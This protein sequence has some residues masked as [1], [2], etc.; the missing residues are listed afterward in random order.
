ME[1]RKSVKRVRAG[2]VAS[3]YPMVD[4]M[5]D[6]LR[7]VRPGKKA[8]KIEKERY[9]HALRCVK[10][11]GRIIIEKNPHFKTATMIRPCFGIWPLSFIPPSSE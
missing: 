5:K 2:T 3:F 9:A 11:M 6:Y 1:K 10:E 7:E 8:S 4:F